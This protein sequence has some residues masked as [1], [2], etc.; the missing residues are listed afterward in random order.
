MNVCPLD[1]HLSLRQN[2]LSYFLL[3]PPLNLTDCEN[4]TKG[5]EAGTLFTRRTE[6]RCGK[7]PWAKLAR[8]PRLDPRSS[9]KTFWFVLPPLRGSGMWGAGSQAPTAKGI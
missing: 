9:P 7:L 4:R 6:Q 1:E 2:F 8:E 5:L 3:A